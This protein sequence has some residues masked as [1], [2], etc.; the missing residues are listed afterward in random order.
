MYVD[1]QLWIGDGMSVRLNLD[2]VTAADEA[3]MPLPTFDLKVH[4]LVYHHMADDGSVEVSFT[5]DHGKAIVTGT[6]YAPYKRP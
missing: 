2:T 4:E 5:I 3:T 6:I 1:N